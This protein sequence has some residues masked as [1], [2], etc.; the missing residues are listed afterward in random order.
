MLEAQVHNY[1]KNFLR[2]LPPSDWI[3]H[4]TM[5]RM[6]AR[7]L[8]L[9]KSTIIQTG[10]NHEQY[11]PSYLIPLLM[12]DTNTTLVLEE[13][14]RIDLINQK[15]P[16]VKGW[17]YEKAGYRFDEG[18]NKLKIVNYEN[19]LQ[20]VFNHQW[21]TD[22]ITL[23]VESEVL[24]EIINQYLT[25]EIN[26]ENVSLWVND[27]DKRNKNIII[28]NIAKLTKLIYSHP[29]NPYNSYL[30]D[31]EEK[32]IIVEI[33]DLILESQD[34][35]NP[36]GNYQFFYSTEVKTNKNHGE[37]FYE[38]LANYKHSLEAE[39]NFIHYFT[40]NHQNQVFFT[41]KASPL[42]LKVSIG[43]IFQQQKLILIAN[44]L[45]AEKLPKEYSYRLGLNLDNFTCLKFA[46]NPQNQ[47]MKIYFPSKIVFPNHPQFTEEVKKEI[48]ALINAVKVNHY[49]III[50]TDDV[51]LQGQITS[52][53]AG[54][55]GSRVKLNHFQI[56][57]NNIMVCDINFWLQHQ[58]NLLTPQLLIFVTLPLPSLENPIISAQVTY[59]KSRKKDWFRLYLLPIAIR[60]IQQATISVR[61]NQGIL[62]LLDNRVNYR[63]Y[64][65]NILQALEP[66]SKIEYFGFDLD[67]G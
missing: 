21:E 56:T 31:K 40:F 5:A 2:Y 59:Y 24:P 6:I 11:Y 30:L 17:L 54:Y 27:T 66:Y 18:E 48:F 62:A 34:Y 42:N 32:R 14:K 61:K 4:L 43:D 13:K 16:S 39:N 26:F 7:G 37:S 46:V 55:F 8:R 49:P 57:K 29:S 53:L 45:D 52:F 67:C 25:Q 10:I 9:E 22:S 1:L 20:E 64:G 58:D 44:Y 23:M 35:I 47:G 50:I 36:S 12:C 41:I 60:N 38:Q 3:H 33:C 51:P 28:D 15:I 19:W 63:S 65:N